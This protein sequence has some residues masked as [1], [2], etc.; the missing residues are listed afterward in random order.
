MEQA[1]QSLKTYFGYDTFRPMQAEIIENIL[2]GNDTLV[3]MPT[4]GGKSICFQIPALVSEG[5]CIVVSPLIAL[6]QD[7]VVGLKENGVA[8]AFIN[9]SLNGK[10][11]MEVENKVIDGEIKL[12]YVSPEKLLS[13][14]FFSFMQRTKISLF[15]ID[16]A[17]CISSWGHDFRPEYTKLQL[18]KQNFPN[19]PVV[20][21]TATADKTTR[22][23]IVS[24]LGLG[25]PTE[26]I[27]SFDRPNLSLSV[28][29]GQKKI[30]QIL[31]FVQKRPNQSGIVY[32]LSR[33]QTE[34]VSDKLNE[35]GI[36]S[37][38]YHAGMNAQDRARVQE[39]FI[40]DKVPIICATVAFGMGID[41]SNVR[42]VIHHN[43]PKNIEGYYQEI[44]RAGRDGL[45]SD[46]LLFYS[47]RDVMMLHDFASQ[48]G[49]PDLQIAK[50]E[51]MQ[52]FAEA[53]IC[54]RRI[55]LSYFG[56]EVDKDCGNCD[57]CKNPPSRFDGTL[58]AQKALSA[59][60]RLKQKV[61]LTL[62]IDILRGSR[63]K[64]VI[65]KGY[66]Q[67]KTYGAGAD[68]SYFDWQMLLYQMLNMGLMDI[69]YDEGHSLKLNNTSNAIL[70]EG[71]KVQLTRE[72]EAERA[73]KITTE[74]P[75]SDKEVLQEDLFA[76]LKNLRKEIADSQGIAPYLVFNDAS[77]QAMSEE[78][79]VTEAAMHKISGV[80]EK[81][82][83]TYGKIFLKE[84][85]L[86]V[87][88][89]AK[90]GMKIKGSTYLLTL[91][92][93]EEGLS[94][95]EIASQREMNIKTVESHIAYLYEHGFNIDVYQFI[96]PE[97]IDVIGKAIEELDK[98][99]GLKPIF[100]HLNQEISYDKIKMA[101]AYWKKKS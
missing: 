42:W 50:L 17:H 78:L 29:P 101:L 41:K 1:Q 47:Y 10:E 84:I 37:G 45:P 79:P 51:R 28:K 27:S 23:D 36:S 100:D 34:Q 64:E 8:A 15:A 81:K 32:C 53:T 87:R 58:L 35:A 40:K 97:E 20:A 70:F 77:I 60:S 72:T 71:K 80:G 95:Y 89:M 83:K 75:K 30:Q 33:K 85:L 55:L 57:V 68:I 14:G 22:K 59:I 44:G 31:A 99:E 2:G 86:F 66:D 56:D 98:P 94:V 3:L 69:A 88:K 52:Q 39:W 48:S 61:S 7:Q 24:Q 54:R 62:L 65:D 74:K 63:K 12:L 46:T 90:E 67:I 93:Y 76:I 96:T 19:T 43:L 49:Q 11:Q 9:S 5:T 82:F 13:Q 38:F 4:G 18:L 21:L 91:E 26:F 16:E 25:N 92:L 73:E 6:M